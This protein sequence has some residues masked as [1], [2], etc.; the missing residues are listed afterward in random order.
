MNRSLFVML[1]L[2]AIILEGTTSFAGPLRDWLASKKNKQET[3]NVTYDDSGDDSTSFRLPIGVKL[4]K[5][6]PYGNHPKQKMDVYMPD[7]TKTAPVIFMVHGGAWKTG[8]KAYSRVVENK[9]SRWVPKGF[10]FISANYRLL[11]DADPLTQASDVAIAISKAQNDAEKWGGNPSKFILMGHSAGAHLVSLI[12]SD[13]K[14]SAKA[15]IRPYL[16]TVS[17]DSAAY[18]I[19]RIMSDK[20]YRFYDRAFGEDPSYW[21]AASPINMISSGSSPFLEV[22]SSKRPDAPCKQAEMFAE[23]AVSFGVK[24]KVLPMN[25]SHADINRLLGTKGEYTDSVEAFMADLDKSVKKIIF[26]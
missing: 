5:D 4:L 23:K 19:E 6:I 2:I 21:K 10:V 25:L 14:I 12:S 16:G 8:D 11:P 20:H 3:E 24:A 17:L 9:V 26:E 1:L 7:K 22:C 15:G 13:K 18:D